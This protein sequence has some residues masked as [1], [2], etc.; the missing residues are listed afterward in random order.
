MPSHEIGEGCYFHNLNGW[1]LFNHA[2][3]RVPKGHDYEMKPMPSVSNAWFPPQKWAPL[4]LLT[5]KRGSM[6]SNMLSHESGERC[7]F[8]NKGVLF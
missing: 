1:M 4:R 5:R 6:R 2:A 3:S 7:Y 8:R